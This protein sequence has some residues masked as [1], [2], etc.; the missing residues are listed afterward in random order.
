MSTIRNAVQLIGNLGKDPELKE[1]SNGK[2]MVKVSLATSDYYISAAGE[3]VQQTQWHNLVAFGKNAQFMEKYLHKGNEV[4]VKGKLT[5]RTFEDKEGNQRMV[6]EVFVN[7]I[8]SLSR[9][10]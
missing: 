10:K 9:N 4:A 3:K 6:T 2:S 8:L 5:Y 7:D 1:L